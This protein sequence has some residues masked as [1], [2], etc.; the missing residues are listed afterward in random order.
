[1]RRSRWPDLPQSL[2]NTDSVQY[3][4]LSATGGAYE[5]PSGAGRTSSLSAQVSLSG[6]R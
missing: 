3:P 2:N 4:G 6:T 5:S 1:M